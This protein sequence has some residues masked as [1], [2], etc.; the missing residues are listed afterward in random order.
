MLFVNEASATH[1]RTDIF[2]MSH[3]TGFL[4][5]LVAIVDFQAVKTRAIF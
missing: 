5:N 3:C 1:Q 2:K 4:R